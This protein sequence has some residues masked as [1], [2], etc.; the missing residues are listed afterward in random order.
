MP[1][2][3]LYWRFENSPLFGVYDSVADALRKRDDV[4]RGGGQRVTIRVRTSPSAQVA[5]VH[6]MIC[7]L[8]QGTSE[9]QDYADEMTRLE[10]ELN[11]SFGDGWA[12]RTANWC[13]GHR[14]TGTEIAL[15]PVANW[16]QF[17]EV[18]AGLTS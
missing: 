18:A 7:D 11:D 6:Y 8:M 2:I 10:V 14:M 9:W 1:R 16:E 12:D 13:T 5:A 4:L 15:W 17:K 3:T